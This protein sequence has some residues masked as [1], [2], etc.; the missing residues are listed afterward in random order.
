MSAVDVFFEVKDEKDTKER[1][2][3]RAS[4][5]SIDNEGKWHVFPPD[6]HNL[7][8]SGL[9]K[10]KIKDSGEGKATGGLPGM[11]TVRSLIRSVLGRL[12]GK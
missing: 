6:W 2:R 1:T 7:D 10:L 8:L 11:A 12:R 3:V 5:I 4:R 9:H